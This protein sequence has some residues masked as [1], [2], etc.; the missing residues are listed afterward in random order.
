MVAAYGKSVVSSALDQNEFV[1]GKASIQEASSVYT[2]SMG[3]LTAIMGAELLQH[4]KTEK[5]QK[6]LQWLWTGEYWQ[7]HNRLKRQ[8]VPDTGEWFWQSIEDLNWISG[9]GQSLICRGIRIAIDLLGADV[10]S[11]SWEVVHHVRFSM[12]WLIFS[13]LVVDKL[14]PQTNNHNTSKTAVLLFYFDYTDPSARTVEAAIRALLKQVIYQ[15]DSLPQ[16]LELIYDQCLNR[17]LSKPEIDTFAEMLVDF[18]EQFSKVFVLIDAYDECLEEDRALLNSWLQRF[19]EYKMLLFLTTRPHP[20]SLDSLVEKLQ[21]V[22]SLEIKAKDDDVKRY[23]IDVL[24]RNPRAEDLHHDLKK[25]I[26][27]HISIGTAGQ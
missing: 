4:D 22:E 16:S 9:S 13:S 7:T 5:R 23:V 6:V 25:K 14:L 20:H 3:S 18:S 12:I 1:K 17:G 19:S 24:E 8:R 2:A 11:W 26:V 27:E 15:L 21:A 10:F